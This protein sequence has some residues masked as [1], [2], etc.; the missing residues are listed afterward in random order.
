M[1]LQTHYVFST[2]VITLFLSILFHNF[3]MNFF[4]AV[5]FSV[6][7]NF[8][9]DKLGHK[10]MFTERGHI[11]VRTPLTHTY[12]RSVF[13]GVLLS[14]PLLFIS[15]HY[16]H[17]L[18]HLHTLVYDII[19]GIIV[20]PSHMFLDMFT[21]A[22]IYVKKDGRWKRFALA[23]YKYNNPF[24]NGLAIIVGVILLFIAHSNYLPF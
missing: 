16:T 20:G 19:P 4:I 13:W 2:G 12:P 23:H 21:E 9:I 11:P 3:Y 24:I 8:L 10:E 5:Y 14:I 18:N 7:G 15:Y 6:I 1:K 17:T 22:G